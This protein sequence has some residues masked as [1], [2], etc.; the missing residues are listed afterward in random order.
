MVTASL[1]PFIAVGVQKYFFFEPFSDIPEGYLRQFVQISDAVVAEIFRF[2]SIVFAYFEAKKGRVWS[3]WFG[4]LASIGIMIY[5]MSVGMEFA[6][7]QML[8]TYLFSCFIGELFGL[9]A[10]LG[11]SFEDVV[12]KM[13]EKSVS[14]TEPGVSETETQAKQKEPKRVSETKQK[15]DSETPMKRNKPVS[16]KQLKHDGTKQKTVSLKQSAE[17]VSVDG[18]SKSFTASQLKSKASLYRL[19]LRNGEGRTETNE[20][21]LKKFETAYFELTKTEL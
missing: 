2:G 11:T 16:T 7:P 20:A 9:R 18:F 3:V 10:I 4:V 19:R 5:D 17:T 1:I 6:N 15:Q 13:K 14:E 21:N 8:K 12:K